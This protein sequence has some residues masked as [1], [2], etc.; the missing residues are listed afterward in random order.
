MTVLNIK[1]LNTRELPGKPSFLSR[2]WQGVLRFDE[3]LN[4]DPRDDLAR[5]IADLER[6]SKP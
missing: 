4:F 5:R 6:K 1:A 2:L 3:A